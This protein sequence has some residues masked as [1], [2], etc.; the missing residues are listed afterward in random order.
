MVLAVFLMGCADTP[1]KRA[2]RLIEEYLEKNAN[3]PSSIEIVAVHPFE[4]DSASVFE[5]TALYDIL[6]EEIADT[7]ERI[8]DNED[9][10]ELAETYREELRRLEGEMQ[11]GKADFNPFFFW[12]AVVEYRGKNAMG[13]LVKKTGKVKLDKEMTTVVGFKDDE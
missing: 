7:K 2:E 6:M 5:S 8:K 13:A 9:V 10:E 3:D 1:E 11:K 12:S 4:A